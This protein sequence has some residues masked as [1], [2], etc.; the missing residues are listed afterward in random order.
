MSFIWK[1]MVG[2]L[3]FIIGY[4]YL[5]S[6]AYALVVDR[7]CVDVD[8]VFARGSGVE[9]DKGEAPHF[10]NQLLE[11]LKQPL[12][13]NFY[14]L[15]TEPYGNYKYP[16]IPVTEWWKNGNAI[17]AGL[18]AGYGN[19]YG[20]S[21]DAGITEL[22]SYL[23]QRHAEC[24]N[25]RIILGGYSQGAQVVGQAL[26][27][28]SSDIQSKIDFVALFGDPKLYLP[29]GEGAHPPACYGAEFS[30]WRRVVENCKADAGS[31]GARNPYVPDSMA[32]KVGLWCKNPFQISQNKKLSC[33]NNLAK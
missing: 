12:E 28:L 18:S 13:T 19:D 31:L 23:K 17:G 27:G 33:A 22:Q 6:G 15:G 24:P 20:D 10:R 11:R 14:E 5:S 3:A 16:A 29:E 21:V 26:T 7:Q 30:S 9:L 1:L 8:V 32:D 2:A 4:S 25:A